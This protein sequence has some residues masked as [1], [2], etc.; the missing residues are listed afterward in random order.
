MIEVLAN[1]G[2]DYKG[3]V[4]RLLYDSPTT[5][6]SISFKCIPAKGKSC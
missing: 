2:S 1:S 5:P 4:G 3:Q 6:S